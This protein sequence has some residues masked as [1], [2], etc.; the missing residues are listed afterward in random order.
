MPASLLAERAEDEQTILE[1][2]RS[3]DLAVQGKVEEV[4]PPGPDRVSTA[5]IRIKEWL[6]G[7]TE[8]KKLWVAQEL[9]F[10][11]DQP[12]Y[13]E[14]KSV[15]LFLDDIP[16]YSRWNDYRSK[17]VA[18][19]AAGNGQGMKELDPKAAGE[20]T[21]FLTTYQELASFRTRDE[22]KEYLDFLLQG[23]GSRVDLVQ[24]A[25]AEALVR[26][27][28]LR[29]LI[30]KDEKETLDRFLQDKI[31][32]RAARRRL[33]R[34]L[35]A[36]EG[37]EES[38]AKV[39]TEE[40]DMRLSILQDM[41]ASGAG[42]RLDHSALESCLRDPD[43]R[44]RTEALRFVSGVTDPAV[45]ERVGEMA[46]SDSS[47]EVRA[48]AVSAASKQAGEAGREILL[49]GLEDSSPLVVYTAADEMRRLGGDASARELGSLLQAGDPRVRFIGILML[50]SMEDAEARAILED[51]SERHTDEKTRDWAGKIL[52]GD[53][54][55]AKSMHQALGVEV[56]P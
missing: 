47:A 40:P 51:A 48:R 35:L 1:L 25:S 18:Y 23:L 45:N 10:P 52:A 32:S 16:A 26:L 43:P 14:G 38:V 41:Y 19:T 33:I 3:C 24:E 56:N 17:G 21:A 29:L 36:W 37:F 55:D 42:K 53:R 39:L 28:D 12:S 44:V 50:G 4:I 30:G 2:L 46:A 27:N 54:L 6:K 31:K 34:T 9:L 22:K 11:S 20:V 7:E 15:L 49:R 5:R 8:E 13:H